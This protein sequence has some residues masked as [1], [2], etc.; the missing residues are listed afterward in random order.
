MQLKYVL[1]VKDHWKDGKQDGIQYSWLINGQPFEEQHWKDGKML[2][3]IEFGV[4]K[5][6][7]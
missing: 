4:G 5:I 7:N 6:D 3:I 1:T 2:R